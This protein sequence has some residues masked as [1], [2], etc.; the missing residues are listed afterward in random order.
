MVSSPISATA[1][2]TRAPW[3]YLASCIL[4]PFHDPGTHDLDLL[5]RFVFGVRLDETQATYDA[6]AGLDAAEDCVL[7]VEPGRGGQRYEE[8]AAVRVRPGVGHTQDSRAGMLEL[9][10]L[11]DLVGELVAVDGGTTTARP[12]RVASLHHEARDDAVEYRLVVV[13]APRQGLEVG[14]CLGR[15]GRVQLDGDCALPARGTKFWLAWGSQVPSKGRRS[16]L[17]MCALTM[18]VSKATSFD[19]LSV[20]AR[21]SWLGGVEPQRSSLVDEE[22]WGGL[23]GSYGTIARLKF[24]GALSP[25]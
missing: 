13:A 11:G 21:A 24:G 9:E 3:T 4:K 15:V 12:R 2:P 10:R 1:A 7:A 17:Y 23:D 25:V 20:G 8:L 18:E 6:H 5:Y 19:I 16:G 14:A 22:A